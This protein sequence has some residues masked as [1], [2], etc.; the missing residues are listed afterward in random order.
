MRNHLATYCWTR[1]ESRQYGSN[2]S[3]AQRTAE[4]LRFRQ[5]Q[6]GTRSG[7]PQSSF[8]ILPASLQL[9]RQ[10]EAQLRQTARA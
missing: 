10:L 4:D 5:G 9:G 6:E 8:F 7:Y 2:H 3:Q 1:I